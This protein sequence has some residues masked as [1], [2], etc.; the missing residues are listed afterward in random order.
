M[1]LDLRPVLE[2][3]TRVLGVFR[4]MECGQSGI[5]VVIDVEGRTL[6]LGAQK[7]EQVDFITYRSD[8]P[9]NVACGAQPRPGRVLA[10]YRSAVSGS[11]DGIAVAIELLPDGYVPR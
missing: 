3:E 6:R 8:Q 4:A 1:T 10:T 7:F 5:S 11:S 9:G 2:G